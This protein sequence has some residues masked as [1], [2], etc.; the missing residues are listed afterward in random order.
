MLVG[1]GAQ[2][3]LVGIG[4]RLQDAQHQRGDFLPHGQ[5]DLRHAVADRQAADQFAQRHQHG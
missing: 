1:E 3:V 5:L 2:Q 4:Q